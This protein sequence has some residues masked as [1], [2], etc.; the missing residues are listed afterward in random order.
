MVSCLYSLVLLFGKSYIMIVFLDIETGGFSKEKNA[1]CEIGLIIATPEL[2]IVHEWQTYIKPYM[3]A[4]GS[5]LC[6]YKL[7]AMA[8]N[9]ITMEQ[10]EGGM[11]V[12][13]A[14]AHF[15]HL[16]KICDKF[17]CHNSDFD[18]G[19][20]KELSLR[21]IRYWEHRGSLDTLELC[22]KRF[23]NQCNKLESVC[24]RLGIEQGNHTALGDA[25]AC[26]EVYKK[27]LAH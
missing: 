27:L 4:D 15:Y 18:L 2:E 6:S 21:L 17:V 11:E 5:K 19:W 23:P 1:L 16:T 22:R 20:L 14:L 9:G 7:D 25:R 13:D 26:M 10:L 24:N 8:V 3:R 12:K